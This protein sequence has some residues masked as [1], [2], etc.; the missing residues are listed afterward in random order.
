MLT[1]FFVASPEE[2]EAAFPTY[3]PVADEPVMR[4]RVNPFTQERVQVREWVPAPGAA[5]RTPPAKKKG[6]SSGRGTGLTH[7]I[8][9]LPHAEWKRVHVVEL[10]TLWA[11]WPGV[12]Y[13]EAVDALAQAKP[14]LV[15]SDDRPESGL[16]QLPNAFVEA[17]AAMDDK[18][19]KAKAKL[20]GKT[21][22]WTAVGATA[23]DLTEIL[24][25]LKELA[26]TAITQ[27]KNLYSWWSL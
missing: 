14:P 9:A 17:L 24:S 19:V 4:E 1:D 3:L 11:T 22:E 12:D 16:M 25:K 15:Q 5:R 2:L 10:A 23:N 20:W 27:R 8:N 26:H 7:D 21:E 13:L 18:T 6:K